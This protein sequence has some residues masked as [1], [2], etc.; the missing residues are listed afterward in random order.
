MK[1]ERDVR[2][3]IGRSIGDIIDIVHT[4]AAEQVALAVVPHKAVGEPE[5]EPEPEP[6]HRHIWDRAELL[7]T[8]ERRARRLPPLVVYTC[9]CNAS[10]IPGSAEQPDCLRTLRRRIDD[11]LASY[12]QPRA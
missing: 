8:T 3:A 10:W 4:F 1:G 11:A 9:E 7:E 12:A 2:E 5:P 6:R